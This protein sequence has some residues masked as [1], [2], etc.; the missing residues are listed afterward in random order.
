[1]KELIDLTPQE[2]ENLVFDLL[3]LLGLKNCV[4]RT[5]G[6]DG[7]RDIQGEYIH[8][9][10]SG[11]SQKEIWYVECKR[12]TGSVDWPTV[13]NKISYAEAQAAD[14]LL[15]A[16]TSSLTPQATDNLNNWN[17]NKKKP[18]IRAW[19]GAEMKNK[20]NIFP[21][22][23][24]RY[25]LVPDPFNNPARS[26]LPLIKILLK[27]NYSLSGSYV[28]LQDCSSQIETLNSLAGLLSKRIEDLE[29]YNK[30]I[31]YKFNPEHDKYEWLHGGKIIEESGFDRYGIITV[32][33]YIRLNLNV[34]KITIEKDGVSLV[35]NNITI[36]TQSFINDLATICLWTNFRIIINETK[37]IL[38]SRENDT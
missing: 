33:S 8:S 5:P 31:F 25:E 23:Q 11:Y 1:M 34:D 32:L 9:D 22:L 15:I 2:F 10:I 21:E 20:L 26:V 38:E 13:W 3:T 27:L 18:L 6:S 30:V 17:G 35:V 19:S 4:W 14:V 29:S 24:A 36:S 12:Y 16:T 28:F 37:L 7:G